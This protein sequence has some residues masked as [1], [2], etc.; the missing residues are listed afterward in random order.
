MIY[1]SKHRCPIHEATIL[2][3]E[4]IVETRKLVVLQNK[5]EYLHAHQIHHV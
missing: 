5:F 4:Y 2:N 3:T 1:I